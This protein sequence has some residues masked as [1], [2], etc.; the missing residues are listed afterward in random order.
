MWE[1][2]SHI[3]TPLNDLAGS[4]KKKDCHWAE[5]ERA[6]FDQAKRMLV[7]GCSEMM[8]YHE[9]MGGCGN[10]NINNFYEVTFGS[11]QNT[12][13]KHQKNATKPLP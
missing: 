10:S 5:I 1:K 6:P 7:Q 3:L 11:Y 2:R 12:T 9:I 13:T 4:K 8:I